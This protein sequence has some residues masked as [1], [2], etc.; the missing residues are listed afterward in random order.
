LCR[1]RETSKS[2]SSRANR[3]QTASLALFLQLRRE[4][5]E[6]S[7]EEFKEAWKNVIAE[8]DVSIFIAL[9]MDPKLEEKVET[10]LKELRLK[11]RLK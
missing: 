7:V 11:K 5:V 1:Y 9:T 8:Y 2:Q 3:R 4:Q 10:C 6:E